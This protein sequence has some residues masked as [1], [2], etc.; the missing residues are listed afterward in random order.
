MKFPTEG[1]SEHKTN[2]EKCS[3]EWKTFQFVQIG[4]S[5]EQ[6]EKGTAITT[7]RIKGLGPINI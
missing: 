2:K 7:K 6:R 4:A 1:G 3:V 5:S